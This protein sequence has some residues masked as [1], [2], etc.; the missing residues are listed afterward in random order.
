MFTHIVCVCLLQIKY[1]EEFEKR[2]M[3]GDHPPSNVSP[4]SLIP[5]SA[6]SFSTKIGLE[7][8]YKS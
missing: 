7:V 5:N 8:V 4:D 1:H 3:G 6:V 2:R